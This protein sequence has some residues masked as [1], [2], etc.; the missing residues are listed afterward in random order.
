MANEDNK[1][2][3]SNILNVTDSPV[4]ATDDQKEPDKKESD[5]PV[6][7]DRTKEWRDDA[8]VMEELEEIYAGVVIPGFD[9]KNDQTMTIERCWDVYNCQ[10]N[11][12]QFYVGNSQVYLPIVHDA[13][14]ARVTRFSN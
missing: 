3:D 8:D 4:D 7:E 13:I 1:K 9:D 12:N 11:E 10:L 2:D 6:W 14:E 5:V